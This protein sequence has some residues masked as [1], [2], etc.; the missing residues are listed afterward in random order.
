MSKKNIKYIVIVCII[1]FVVW[2]IGEI[3][4]MVAF[5]LSSMTVARAWVVAVFTTACIW[6]IVHMIREDKKQQE[7]EDNDNY[8]GVY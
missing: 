3:I 4:L 7:D 2:L 5:P 1:A 8:K 6:C